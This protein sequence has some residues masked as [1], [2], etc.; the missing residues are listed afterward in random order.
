LFRLIKWLLL[1]TPIMALGL[2]VASLEQSSA[3]STAANP[4]LDKSI[5]RTVL[6][7]VHPSQIPPGESKQLQFNPTQLSAIANTLLKRLANLQSTFQ[8][9]DNQMHFTL[10][11]ELPLIDSWRYLNVHGVV[12]K[13]NGHPALTTLQLGS[14]RIPTTL[15]NLIS[16]PLIE[17]AHRRFEYQLAALVIE[18]WSIDPQYLSF[19]VRWRTDVVEKA[20]EQLLA[21]ANQRAVQFYTDQLIYWQHSGGDQFGDLR[22]LLNHLFSIAVQRSGLYD[23]RTDNQAIF[24]ALGA[25]ATRQLKHPLVS[26]ETVTP[27]GFYLKIHKRTDLARHFLIAAAYAA[28]GNRQASDRLGLLKELND[29]HR[30]SG[31]S[32]T[33]L[34][35]G[36]AGA[37]VGE[38]ATNRSPDAMLLQDKLARSANDNDF[39]PNVSALPEHL[40]PAE[41]NARFHGSDSPE[42]Q[43]LM[44]QIDLDI[45]AL[46]ILSH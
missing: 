11:L 18:Q 44:L 46:P 35:A 41:F 40:K 26:D 30:G 27:K 15:V 14:L 23:A 9:S 38:F 28:H 37:R 22:P 12:A 10:S 16:E 36:L 34:A 25:W 20:F 42:F 1:L 7:R 8:L 17:I 5:T 13:Q 39:M 29:T 24:S 21:G 43:Q 45:N 31:F 2:L 4:E 33:D 32:F 3:I 19:Q 6:Q